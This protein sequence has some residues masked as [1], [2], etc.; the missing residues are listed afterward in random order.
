M[1]AACQKYRKVFHHPSADHR[2]IREDNDRHQSCQNPQKSKPGIQSLKC[3]DG[4]KSCLSPDGHFRDHQ[5][6]SKGNRQDQIDQKEGAPSILRGKIGKPPDI[7]KSNRRTGSSQDKS[8]L[9]GKTASL[10]HL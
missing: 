8:Q 10:V 2:I 5:R 9:A 7:P 6:K 3:S 1:G 4:A